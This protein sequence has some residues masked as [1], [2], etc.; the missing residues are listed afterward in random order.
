MLN[1]EC[2]Y[3]S[4]KNGTA[5]DDG[6]KL[7]GHIS[8]E[9]NLTCKKIWKEFGMKNMGDYHDRYLKKDV[10]LLADVFEKFI[11]TS[12][13]FYRLHPCHYFSSSELSWDAMLKI[14]KVDMYLFI[15]KGLREGISY[16]AK[17][18]GKANNNYM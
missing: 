1:R 4:V 15:E 9:D 12:L 3:S 14:S 18:Y 11:N 7:D 13:E 2:F 17:R 8:D 6:K 5:G 10:L 16:I